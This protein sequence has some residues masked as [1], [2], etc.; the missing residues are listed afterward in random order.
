MIVLVTGYAGAGKDTF[1]DL[2]AKKGFRKYVFSEALAE[3]FERR[4]ERKPKDKKELSDF[5]AKIRE[6]LGNDAVARLVWK[7]ISKEGA[8][9]VV[10]S[11]C[12]SIEEVK[13]FEHKGEVVVVVEVRADP[14]VR[15]KRRPGALERDELDKKLG[16]EDVIKRADV[17]VENNGTIAEL[18]R[19]VDY[20][21]Q[22]IK[23][24]ALGLKAGLEIHQQ[25]D[26]HKLFCRCP[27][28]IREDEPDIVVER[29]QRPV[30]SELG[31]FDPAALTEFR[32]GKKYVYQAYSDTT[33]LVEL[34]EEPPMPPNEEALNIALTV[35]EYM[36]MHVFPLVQVMRK[37]VIDGSNTTGF[38]RTMLLAKNG[39]IGGPLAKVR[40][41]TL[42]LEEDAARVIERGKDYVI[43][44]LDRLG[45]PLV[46]ITTKPDLHSPDEVKRAAERIGL[47][48]RATGKVKRG[49][50]T[51]RQDIN[52]SIR[53]GAR[54]EIKGVQRLDIIDKYVEYEV[55]R[56][57]RL[58]EIKK[59]LNRRTHKDEI[60]VKIAD[61]SVAFENT[62]CKFVAKA[63]KQGKKVLGVRLPKL[64]GILGI[65][66]QP[67]RRFGTELSD[68]AKVHAG[69]GGILHSDELPAY[70]I[71]EEE[72]CKV[73]EILECEE[74]DAFVLVVDKEEKARRALE[75]VVER[76]KTAFDGVPEETRGPNEDGTTRYMRPLPGAARM[77]PE[78]DVA[79][80]VISEERL[81]QIRETLPP[82]PEERREEYLKLGLSD[83]IVERLIRS[84]KVF[85]FDE[86]IKRGANP[87][88]A[89][90]LLLNK[91]V[92][93][94]REGLNVDNISEEDI[95]ALA[96]GYEKEY[97]KE[98]L[99]NIVK[100][101]CEGYSYAEALR[102][103]GAGI[104][105]EEY[106]RKVVLEVVKEFKD[107]GKEL[108][109]GALMG[110]IMRRL[111]GKAS[112]RI[113]SK[114]LSKVLKES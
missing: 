24:Y 34:D 81:R 94:R 10:I 15:E 100:Y 40:I 13:F 16:L 17:V 80:I 70:G 69:V 36:H 33:C 42:C 8:E 14:D 99:D 68:Y 52:I 44:R 79:P 98:Q 65:Q 29:F 5:G 96:L 28:L 50:G 106:I 18:E 67:G 91:L 6:E 35:A 82:L 32:K 26:T 104:V 93:W 4:F 23:Y 105:G 63:L 61:V 87:K 83:D 86:M 51:I 71:S 85:L 31:E 97:T 57:L 76:I 20:F 109:F 27:S 92:Y 59:E 112:G 74:G 45:I 102:K 22:N 77:Y 54:V 19:K 89:A 75:V 90:T 3:E 53:G 37:I 73:R 48:L 41:S 107:A 55:M 12:R 101:L 88:F 113:V 11:G 2:L 84:P 49:L 78:T 103:A 43:Y 21:L 64:E 7:K 95:M 9:N 111:Q 1:A 56:Q 25:L 38:Q 62:K 72:V 47:L 60:E 108:K 46:E 58:L 114:V 30:A 110:E 66:V 39:W